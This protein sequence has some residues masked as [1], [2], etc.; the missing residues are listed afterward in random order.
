MKTVE[1]NPKVKQAIDSAFNRTSQ[2]WME[3]FGHEQAELHR[4]IRAKK[5]QMKKEAEVRQMTNESIEPL[6][7]DTVTGSLL[8]S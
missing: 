2:E 1:M 4:K 6:P 3:K 7:G 5:E 8:N